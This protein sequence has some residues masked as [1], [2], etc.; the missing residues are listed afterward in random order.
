MAA[1]P[2]QSVVVDH[3]DAVISQRDVAVAF[4][5]VS[6]ADQEILRLVAWERLTPPR[7]RSCSAARERRSRCG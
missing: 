5:Q 2:D 1:E 4:A 3:A 6:G 7:R